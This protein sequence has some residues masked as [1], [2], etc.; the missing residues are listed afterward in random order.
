V[1]GI[2]LDSCGNLI[3]TWPAQAHLE[4]DGTY[5]ATQ[6]SGPNLICKSAVATTSGGGG[7]NHP[8]GN[9]GS[10]KTG[11]GGSLPGTG[12]HPLLALVAL[13]TVGAALAS[14]AWR[15]KRN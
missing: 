8:Q 11:S 7:S 2:A 14:A 5:V 1:F 13:A 10:T 15:R 3:T 12:S 4:S 6:T 9:G